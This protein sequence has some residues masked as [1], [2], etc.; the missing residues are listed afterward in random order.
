MKPL[1]SHG[2]IQWRPKASHSTI[3]TSLSID[4]TAAL[5]TV[6]YSG[7]GLGEVPVQPR[8]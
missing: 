6:E 5:W 7:D 1:K 3:P 8:W 2:T 4:V